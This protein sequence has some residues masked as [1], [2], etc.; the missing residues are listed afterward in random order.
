[1]RFFSKKMTPSVLA[2]F[3]AAILLFACNNEPKREMCGTKSDCGSP[4]SVNNTDPDIKAAH[5]AIA[6]RWKL[7]EVRTIDTFRKKPGRYGDSNMRRS[8]CISYDG[9]IQY[10]LNY[11]ELTCKLCY[12]IS[13]KDGKLQFDVSETDNKFCAESI[14]SSQLTV[15]GDSLVLFRRDSFIEKTFVF[16]RMNED[17]TFRG[18]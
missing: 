16:K 18:K 4:V 8:M 1:M 6:D 3:S 10:F 5:E 12:K 17:G 7:Y 13:K 14:P 15:A 2:A 11:K 9:A